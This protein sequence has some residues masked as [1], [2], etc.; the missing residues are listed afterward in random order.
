[1]DALSTSALLKLK[2]IEKG[3]IF[4]HVITNDLALSSPNFYE[5]VEI[6]ILAKT[7]VEEHPFAYFVNSLMVRL[8]QTFRVGFYCKKFTMAF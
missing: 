4:T 7:F 1:M 2:Q 3:K 5:Q 8:A 6:L